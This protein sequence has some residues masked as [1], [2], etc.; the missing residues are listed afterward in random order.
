MPVWGDWGVHQVGL[1]HCL[2][3]YQESGTMCYSSTSQCCQIQAACHSPVKIRLSPESPMKGKSALLKLECNRGPLCVQSGLWRQQCHLSLLQI[4]SGCCQAALV[5]CAGSS[6]LPEL[7]A[8]H[9]ATPLQ[10]SSS[11]LSVRNTLRSV[12]RR[13]MASS[14]SACQNTSRWCLSA[15]CAPYRLQCCMN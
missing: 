6:F 13:S 3:V 4:P 14:E 11:S 12:M 10:S 7:Q 2:C 15:L 1:G 5:P 8:M 9:Q